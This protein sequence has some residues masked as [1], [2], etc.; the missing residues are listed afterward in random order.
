MTCAF[1]AGC[2]GGGPSASPAVPADTARPTG[3]AAPAST[4]T[5]S[6]PSAPSA[7]PGAGSPTTGSPA[8]ACVTQVLG[9]LTLAQRVGELFLVG[10]EG[11]IAGP[12][13]TAAERTYHFGSLLLNKTAAGTAALEAQTAA[14]QELAPA[15]TSG[16]RL[17]IAANQEGGQIQQLS[18]PGFAMMPSALEQG[19]WSLSTLRASATDWG[20]DLR[21][22][23]VNLDLAPVMD[24]V[25]QGSAAS[26]APIGALDREFGFDPVT[27]GQHGTAFIQGMAAAGVMTVA[28]HFPGLG[29]VAGNTDF[30]SNVVDNVTTATDPYLNS[31]RTAIGAGVP[32]VMVALATYTK[33]DPAQLA[34][35]SP[36][37]MRLLRN[38]LGFNGV[39]VSDDM[40]Q[41]AAVQAVPVGGRAIDFLAAGGDL[42]TSQSLAPAEQ[43]AA[44][45]L[46]KASG[47]AAFRA[48]VDSAAQRVLAAKRAAGLLPC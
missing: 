35:F 11:N 46:A 16:V 39:I 10:V 21:A 37:V 6:A 34:V 14:M 12:E 23:G 5:A 43:M 9:N 17:F 26:N 36:T 28:K 7:A 18:G 47:N 27:N 32:M 15:D 38:G 48:T 41:A 25:P 29:R 44:A 22:A 24:V 33:I 42:V 40:G 31:F 1:I 3:T 20:T 4:G 30:T 13:L 45:V 8:A 19:A 2:A